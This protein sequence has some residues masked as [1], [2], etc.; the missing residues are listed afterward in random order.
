MR[1]SGGNVD[2]TAGTGFRG[3][4]P[5]ALV[6]LTV[7]PAEGGQPV[8]IWMRP[9]E[10]RAVGLDLIGAGHAS[11]ADSVIRRTAKRHGIDGDSLIGEL[12]ALT[13]AELGPG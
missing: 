12:R 8:V 13:N 9:I 10:A 7:Q 5:L 4:D 6:R 1:L 2:V 3:D 11:I